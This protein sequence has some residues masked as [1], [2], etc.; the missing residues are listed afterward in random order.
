VLT[1][2]EQLIRLI[3]VRIADT[4]KPVTEVTKHLCKSGRLPAVLTSSG[5]VSAN[6][7]AALLEHFKPSREEAQLWLLLFLEERLRRTAGGVAWVKAA[8][9]RTEELEKAAEEGHVAR[10][11]T[12]LRELRIQRLADV[13]HAMSPQPRAADLMFAVLSGLRPPDG[14][15]APV[16][17]WPTAEELMAR[18]NSPAFGEAAANP[19]SYVRDVLARLRHRGFIKSSVILRPRHVYGRTKSQKLRTHALTHLGLKRLDE[20][21]A[22]KRELERCP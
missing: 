16:E 18:I 2:N 6:Q 20:Y 15:E 4:G 11:A 5:T 9:G 3:R 8:F 14:F 17:T 7:L 22:A 19:L 1:P 10:Q 21:L 12:Q 13:Q